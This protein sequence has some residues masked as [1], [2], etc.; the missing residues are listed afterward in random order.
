MKIKFEKYPFDVII[1][2]VCSIILL[3]IE[4]MDI[5]GTI[6][7]IL[8]LPFILFIPGYVLIFALFPTRK[9]DRGIDIIERIALSI[10]LSVSVVP[11]IGLLLNYT[12]FGIRLLPNL[13]SIFIFVMVI[14]SIGIFLWFKT[15]LEE[16]FIVQFDISL[17]KSESNLDKALNIILIITIIIAISSLIYVIASPKI[18]ERFTEFYILGPDGIAEDYPRFVHLGDK[19]EGIVGIVNHEYTTINYTLEI[20]LINQETLYNETIEENITLVYNMW[21]IEKI[22]TT[23]D[24][25]PLDLESSW[26]SQW[27]TEFSVP[28]DK[29]GSFKLEFLLF[30]NSTP[31][32]EINNDYKDIAEEKINNAYRELHLWIDI[33]YT[34]F[35]IYGPEKTQES[36]YRNINTGDNISG[37]IDL[38]NHEFSSINYT[39]EAW[40]LNETTTYNEIDQK[41]I[42]TIQNMWFVD[43]VNILLNH[44]DN[45]T[46]WEKEYSY[47]I[48]RT[49]SFRFVFLLY[50][51]PTEGY[52]K[53]FD[54]VEK[55]KIKFLTAYDEISINVDVI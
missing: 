47:Y 21:F 53:D 40:L 33:S 50:T 17:P 26:E 52:I 27:E 38:V 36:Y 20:W 34:T 12:P 19:A 10:G 35:N 41:N 45:K 28:I 29:N 4:I 54:Y 23:L 31:E 7:I 43:K 11:L 49:G 39:I 15:D 8:G 5:E 6:R 14:G 37:S 42:T 55:S 2:M 9:T 25:K 13:I 24:H 1:F 46:Q 16:R 32:Y 44:T 3:P 18:G 51:L 48:N 30:T 22:E